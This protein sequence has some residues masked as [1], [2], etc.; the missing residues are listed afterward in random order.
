[1]AGV[2]LIAL[3]VLTW[4]VATTPA[5]EEVNTDAAATLHDSEDT[6]Y[7]RL[8]GSTFK[9]SSVRGQVRVVNVWASWN[10]TSAQE[11]SQLDSLAA[12]FSARS[13][14]FI[15]V[16]RKEP[17]SRIE[18]YLNQQPTLDNLTII[19]DETDAYYEAVSGYAMPETRIYD[20]EGNI[21]TTIRGPFD[22]ADI[23]TII[24]SLTQ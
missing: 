7:S 11:L 21:H 12:D 24:E 2:I 14:A 5:R 10:P 18:A 15:A 17:R 13:V 1:M 19:I 6:P 9:F 23:R 3:G 22:P 4:Y 16:N 8:D 20:K